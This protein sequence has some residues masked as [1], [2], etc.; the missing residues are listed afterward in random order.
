M[1]S[2]Q[3]KITKTRRTSR[4]TRPQSS[5]RPSPRPPLQL[6]HTTAAATPPSSRIITAAPSTTPSRVSLT[7][8]GKRT[9]YL[10]R[11]FYLTNSCLAFTV[12]PLRPISCRHLRLRMALPPLP[13]LS[14][15]PPPTTTMS[16]P[17]MDQSPGVTRRKRPFRVVVTA[18]ENA[19]TIAQHNQQTFFTSFPFPNLFSQFCL[20][21][22][23][24]LESAYCTFIW[25]STLSLHFLLFK[26]PYFL[27][28][29]YIIFSLLF[30]FVLTT[31]VATRLKISAHHTIQK[32]FSKSILL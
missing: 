32:A 15:P 4:T 22:V 26:M 18:S 30:Y 20:N 3:K 6:Q 13:P 5:T 27:S 19:I 1:E 12:K 29:S 17:P 7:T 9:F 23:I 28:F 24:L 31:S 25:R 16:S 8:C 21:L 2:F 11:P 10:R 14:Q